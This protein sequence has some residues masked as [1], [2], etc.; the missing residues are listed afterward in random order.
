MFNIINLY[1]RIRS[2]RITCIAWKNNERST[3]VWWWSDKEFL[4]RSQV[5]FNCAS[6]VN[7]DRTE[8]NGNLC[9]ICFICLGSL[10]INILLFEANNVIFSINFMIFCLQSGTWRPLNVDEASGSWCIWNTIFLQ[11]NKQSN[12]LVRP[13]LLI[14]TLIYNNSTRFLE[15][16]N[17]NDFILGLI[18]SVFISSL[19]SLSLSGELNPVGFL[20]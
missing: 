3:F 6:I 8:S 5:F 15:E 10:S 19:E 11:S 4:D 2:L 1:E 12:W 7:F 20:W 9:Y 17:A 14:I 18:E 16:L 13:S